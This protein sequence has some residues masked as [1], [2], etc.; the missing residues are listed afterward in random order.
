MRIALVGV[1]S[2]ALVFTACAP[3]APQSGATVPGGE[4]RLADN[5]VINVGIHALAASMDPMATL[6]TNPRRNGVFEALVGQSPTGEI[7]PELASEWRMIDA[8]TWQFRM[9]PGRRWHDGQPVT[10]DDVVFTYARA[11]EPARRSPIVSRLGNIR[12]AVK[13]DDQ[14]V[15]IVTSEPEALMLRRVMMAPILPKHYIERVGDQAFENTAIGS[16][17][18]RVLEWNPNDRLFLIANPD[19]PRRP[20]ITR[21]NI[22]IIPEPSARLAGLRTGELDLANRLPFEQVDVIQRLNFQLVP[23]DAGFSWGAWMD[24]TIEGSPTRDRRVR[25]ALNY[26]IDKETMARVIYRGFT[27]PEQGQVIQR[28]TFGFNP[29]LRPYPYD[30]PRARQLLAEAGY[31][32]GFRMRTDA[33]IFN[34]EAAQVWPFLQQQFRDIGVEIEINTY[35]DAATNSD[36]FNGRVARA[37]ITSVSLTNLPAADADFALVWFSPSLQQGLARR[38][39]NPEFDRVYE[40]STREMDPQRREQLLRQAVRILHEDPGWLSLTTTATGWARRTAVQGITDRL[41]DGDWS[42]F[43]TIRIQRS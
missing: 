22:R 5:Q 31:P 14:T 17:P 40:A 13:V 20:T 2:V 16:G 43:E 21:L 12:A 39:D 15:N 11:F 33:Y 37:P 42:R 32:N 6:G 4:E 24:S 36:K 27:I 1:L 19:H 29:N 38:Y 35:S 23:F 9:A 10:V 41:P 26:A 7:V 25:Q 28:E 18:F 34:A 8:R 30:P 3:S